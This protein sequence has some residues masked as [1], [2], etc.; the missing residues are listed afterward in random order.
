MSL[1]RR[2]QQPHEERSGTLRRVVGEQRL[3]EDAEEDELLV[4]GDPKLVAELPVLPRLNRTDAPKRSSSSV[5]FSKIVWFLLVSFFQ[6]N[7]LV[8]HRTLM[9]RMTFSV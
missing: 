6:P 2:T 8:V 7:A 5:P 4:V 9:H 3:P 1:E